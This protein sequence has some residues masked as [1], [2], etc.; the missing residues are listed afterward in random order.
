MSRLQR[1]LFK[2]PNYLYRWKLGSAMSLRFLQIKHIGRKSGL[3]RETVLE[4]IES[5]EG[6]PVI[7]A[8]FGENSAWLL[9]IT[10][11]PNVN[12]TWGS[13]QFQATAVRLNGDDA[14]GVLTRYL[15]NH[16]KAAKTFQSRLGIPLDDPEK[17]AQLLPTLRLVRR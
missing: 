11:N 16:P 7:A 2:A 5:P 15:S 3:P 8:G 4:V 1:W 13:D 17:A 10:A 6:N 9:N 14:T 12:V